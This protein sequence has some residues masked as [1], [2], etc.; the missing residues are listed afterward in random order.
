MKKLANIVK[1]LS[2]LYQ[3][4]KRNIPS[5]EFLEDEMCSASGLE[6]DDS[7]TLLFI[8]IDSHYLK[9]IGS[10]CGRIGNKVFSKKSLVGFL[11][12]RGVEYILGVFN[13]PDSEYSYDGK[14]IGLSSIAIKITERDGEAFED[15]VRKFNGS[16]RYEKSCV[17]GWSFYESE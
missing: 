17:D 12:D 8:P 6:P 5:I 9:N 2:A 3:K 7:Y 10:A 1:E 14:Y 15:L 16:F 4:E 13:E 11:R